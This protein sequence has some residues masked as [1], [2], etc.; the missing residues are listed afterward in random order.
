MTEQLRQ[1]RAIL[2]LL[3]PEIINKILNGGGV[4][5]SKGTQR[6]HPARTH[7]HSQLPKLS[8][9]ERKHYSPEKISWICETRECVSCNPS[10]TPRHHPLFP[11]LL[12]V[13]SSPSFLWVRGAFWEGAKRGNA[14]T[15]GQ[16]CMRSPISALNVC[17]LCGTTHEPLVQPPR[18]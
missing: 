8:D 10:P 9:V 1:T 18:L 15:P 17:S 13:S 3:T 5:L 14:L 2:K 11:S 4:R 7:T 6:T 16:T 12:P